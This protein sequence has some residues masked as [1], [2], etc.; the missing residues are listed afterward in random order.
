M[1]TKVRQPGQLKK[2]HCP[3]LALGFRDAAKLEA[4]SNVVE[5]VEPRQQRVLLEHHAT[6]GSGPC[7]LITQF[8]ATADLLRDLPLKISKG[9]HSTARLDEPRHEIEECGFAAS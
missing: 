7:D 8:G 3:L 2:M 9:D 5:H 4:K 6:L 1:F